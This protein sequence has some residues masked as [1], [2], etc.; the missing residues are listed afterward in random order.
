MAIE[1][2]NFVELVVLTNSFVICFQGLPTPSPTPTLPSCVICTDRSACIPLNKTC[3]FHSDCKDNT[4]EDSDLCGWP[5]NFQTGTCSWTNT[6][7]D[8]FDW[9]RHKGCT[10]SVNTGPCN[11]ADNKTDGI[12]LSL[13]IFCIRT[14][15]NVLFLLT[16][17]LTSFSF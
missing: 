7:Q 13:Q 4:D 5:C 11:D 10:S 12:F 1:T 9:T 14:R 8:N 16:I 17:L 6:H 2:F 15:L 3:D